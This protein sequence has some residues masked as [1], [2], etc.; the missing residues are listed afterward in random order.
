MSGSLM[1]IWI[2]FLQSTEGV[3]VGASERDGTEAG[4]T[5]ISFFRL[6]WTGE[7]AARAAED[8]FVSAAHA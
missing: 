5:A 3:P 4:E 2:L 1:G 8:W 7:N 6:S